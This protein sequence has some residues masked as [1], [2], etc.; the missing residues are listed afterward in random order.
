MAVLC[1]SG[2]RC[3]LGLPRPDGLRHMTSPADIN[4]LMGCETSGA[5]RE[6][7]L[8]LRFDAF[9]FDLLPADTPNNRHLRDDIHR[10]I[11]EPTWDLM[12]IKHP[13][14]TRLCGAGQLW[15]LSPGE[16]HK[17]WRSL[18]KL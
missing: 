18:P 7:F 17:A 16:T 15:L 13:P 4:L 12:C 2:R 5:M 11:I 10:V 14:R 9:S 6:V 3:S 8:A 1:L